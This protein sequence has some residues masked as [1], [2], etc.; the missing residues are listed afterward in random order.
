MMKLLITLLFLGLLLAVFLAFSRRPPMPPEHTLSYQLLQLG[1]FD[2]ATD[3]H[4][5]VDP[6][7]F[8]PDPDAPNGKSPRSMKVRLW[9]PQSARHD[10]QPLLIYSHGLLGTGEA[11]KYIA[12]VLGSHGYVVAAPNFPRTNRS[13]GEQAHARDVFNQPRD[14]ALLIDWLLARSEDQEDELHNAIDPQRIA[15]LGHSLGSLNAHLLGFHPEWQE[16]RIKA[17]VSLAGPTALFTRKFLTTRSIPYMA[18]AGT[19]DAFMEYE[20]NFL[21]LLDKVDGAV[22]VSMEGASHLAFADEGKWFRWFE[23]PDEVGCAFAGKTIDRN[24]RSD[25]PWYDE[26]GGIEEGYV[27][28]IDPNVCEYEVSSAINPLRQQQ[29][30]VMAVH[31]FL[32]CQFAETPDDRERWCGYLRESLDRENQEISLLR[33]N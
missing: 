8:I 27:Q 24:K 29:L 17:V 21:P 32:E 18:I 3:T 4:E 26:L 7:R 33:R 11:V 13:Q 10:P 6:A 1:P 19:E 22:L 5:L 15:A 14:V 28:E 20:R 30:T 31:S 12:R 9:H 2:V 23:Q 16:P 25:E